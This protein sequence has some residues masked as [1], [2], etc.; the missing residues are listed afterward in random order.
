MSQTRTHS[1]SHSD[2]LYRLVKDTYDR[3]DWAY[4]APIIDDINRLKAEKN[5]IIL[6]HNYMTPD[7]YHCVADVV[8]DSLALAVKATSIKGRI[9]VVAGVYFMAETA[10]I[11]NPNTKV[12]IPDDRAG[13]SLADSITGSDVRNLKKNNLGVPVVTYVNTTAEVKAESDIC[14]TSGNVES[15]VR[16]LNVDKVILIPDKYLAKNVE[17]TTGV[18]CITWENGLCEVHK[19]F[20]KQEIDILRKDKPGVRV[21]AHPECSQEVV[22]N[23]DFSGSTAKMISYVR[24]RKPKEVALI[25]ECSLSHNIQQETPK[26]KFVGTCRMCPHMKRITLENIR[27]ALETEAREVTLDADVLYRARRA[28][29]RMI[30]SH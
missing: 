10:K 25:T 22:A 26:T 4:V 18:K 9:I 12:L 3:Q 13:C 23:A 5:A 2:Q 28:V 6:A 15:I 30:A 16:S 21:I 24:K 20:T 14:C 27:T 19:L 1:A 29:D 8:G 7:I 17:K 11:L